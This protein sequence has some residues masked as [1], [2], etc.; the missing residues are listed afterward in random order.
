MDETDIMGFLDVLAETEKDSFLN[1]NV[2]NKAKMERWSKKLKCKWTRPGRNTLNR[3][4]K[5]AIKYAPWRSTKKWT[6][7]GVL[8]LMLRDEKYRDPSQWNDEEQA[9]FPEVYIRLLTLKKAKTLSKRTC[10]GC[11][12]SVYLLHKDTT[13]EE[14]CKRCLNTR[15]EERAYNEAH[16]KLLDRKNK[17]EEE[18]AKKL[19]D[20]FT[21]NEEVQFTVT[22]EDIRKNGRHLYKVGDKVTV[23][24]NGKKDGEINPDYIRVYFPKSETHPRGLRKSVLVAHLQNDTHRRRL[25]SPLTNLADLITSAKGQAERNR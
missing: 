5:E 21:K 19:P 6:R 20:G 11:N 24:G 16:K 9:D 17:A 10:P 18:Q 14:I 13:G 7:M 12:K 1:D 3:S 25:I 15:R 4:N 23:I 2:Y 22:S 8:K